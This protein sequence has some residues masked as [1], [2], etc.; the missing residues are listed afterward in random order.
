MTEQNK[1]DID[2]RALLLDICFDRVTH[3]VLADLDA[4][5]Q[6]LAP[7]LSQNERYDLICGI[8][9]KTN[10]ILQNH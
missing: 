3:P 2:L 4:C 1:N 7:D 6:R 8:I 10:Q 9:V 5:L